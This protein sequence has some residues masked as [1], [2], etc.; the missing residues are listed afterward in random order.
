[1]SF[2]LYVCGLDCLVGLSTEAR[3]RVKIGNSRRDYHVC[4][5]PKMPHS[6]V[7]HDRGGQVYI[8]AIPIHVQSNPMEEN[9]GTYSVT[10]R[11]TPT[12]LEPILRCRY[13]SIEGK[14]LLSWETCSTFV[15]SM[16][17][18]NSCKKELI[19]ARND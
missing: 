8:E 17:Y 14:S 5:L 16:K 3:G 10:A 13:S 12:A 2:I 18:S 15:I 7:M 1:M 19:C 9:I 4:F 11:H 6:D